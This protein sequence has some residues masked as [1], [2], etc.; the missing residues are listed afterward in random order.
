MAQSPKWLHVTYHA[1][2]DMESGF[3]PAARL[4]P[5][6][7]C[8]KALIAQYV[9][10]SSHISP[11]VHTLPECRKTEAKSIDRPSRNRRLF[12]WPYWPACPPGQLGTSFLR[13]DNLG[14]LDG[15]D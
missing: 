7:K 11:Q 5:T 1:A 8:T 2:L 10:G 6:K 13:R 9:D 12:I 15:N 4:P 3:D 14:T